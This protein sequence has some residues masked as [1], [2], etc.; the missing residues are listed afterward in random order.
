MLVE[1]CTVEGMRTI[2]LDAQGEPLPEHAPQSGK[3]FCP[4]CHGL[5]DVLL[6]APPGLAGPAWFSTIVA[7]RGEGAGHIR[8]PA[9]APPYSTRAPPVTA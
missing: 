4:L 3:A 7:W 5:P 6:P 2:R 8:P 1:I 9:R